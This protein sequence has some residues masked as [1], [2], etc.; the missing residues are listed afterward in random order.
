MK[1][2]LARHLEMK[3]LGLLDHFVAVTF[4]RKE[5]EA[6]LTQNQY[7]LQVLKRFGMPDCRPVYTPMETA[8]SRANANNMKASDQTLC[9]EAVGSLLYLSTRTRPDIS[10][11]VG[12]LARHSAN[13]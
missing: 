5:K 3:E 9:Q 13:P 11:A 7:T 2:E 12:I 4:F 10:G 8:S 6:W 1:R